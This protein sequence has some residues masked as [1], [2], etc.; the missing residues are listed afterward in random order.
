MDWLEFRIFFDAVRE[1]S[2]APID[3]YD[4]AVW[5]SISCPSEQSIVMG[6]M[7]VAV[8]DFTDG[9]WLVRRP[10]EPELK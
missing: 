9:Q 10:W 3:V 4:A 5:M 2:P 1:K 8:P 7:P 6:G